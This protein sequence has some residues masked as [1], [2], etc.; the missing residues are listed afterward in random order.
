L[1][2]KT[3]AG[4]R[5]IVVFF[6][7]DPLAERVPSTTDVPPQQLEWASAEMDKIKTSRDLPDLPNEL[8]K[9]VEDESGLMS[10]SQAKE[11]RLDL[12]NER[13]YQVEENT[14]IVFE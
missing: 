11:I 1:L 10:L 7:C 6:L 9:A 12:M 3:K 14:K 4:K 2:D 8:W 5:T 13:K